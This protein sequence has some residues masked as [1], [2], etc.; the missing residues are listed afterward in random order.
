V[1][2]IPHLLQDLPASA[3]IANEAAPRNKIVFWGALRV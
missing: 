3:A 2:V 1:I